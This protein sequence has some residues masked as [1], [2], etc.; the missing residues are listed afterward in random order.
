MYI[1]KNGEYINDGR[2]PPDTLF[3]EFEGRSPGSDGVD[4]PEN[5]DGETYEFEMWTEHDLWYHN[6][7]LRTPKPD[8]LDVTDE[9]WQG[10]LAQNSDYY[11]AHPYYVYD[12]LKE[13]VLA[14]IGLEPTPDNCISA[15]IDPA[16]V[17][18]FA[19]VDGEVDL[20]SPKLELFYRG[21]VN[22][23]P[24]AYLADQFC[25]EKFGRS[26]VE[27]ANRNLSQTS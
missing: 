13:L 5:F 11:T 6:V 25:Q 10:F 14:A 17:T 4:V 7:Y 26:I 16:F 27:L 22:C 21:D 1:F 24:V 8:Y 12:T 3:A 2:L 9:T 15:I 18:P 19:T 23:P 20:R